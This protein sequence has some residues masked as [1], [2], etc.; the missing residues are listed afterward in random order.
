VGKGGPLAI[1][2]ADG[3]EQIFVLEGDVFICCWSVDV[4]TGEKDV[5]P[6]LGN[7]GIGDI[8]C[9]CEG[10]VKEGGCARHDKG[11]VGVGVLEGAKDGVRGGIAVCD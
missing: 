10:S 5:G 6:N 11:G 1:I 8:G 7:D 3:G 4:L 9:D 2:V